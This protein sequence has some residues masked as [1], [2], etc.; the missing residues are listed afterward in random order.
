LINRSLIFADLLLA[1]RALVF[2]VLIRGRPLSSLRLPA[3]FFRLDAW[4]G[5]SVK[6]PCIKLPQVF[7]FATPKKGQASLGR[8]LIALPRLACCG[9]AIL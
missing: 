2:S 9:A 3:I 5:F 7:D 6:P 4:L 1:L 8:P